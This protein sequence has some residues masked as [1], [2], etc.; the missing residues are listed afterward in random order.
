VKVP[1]ADTEDGLHETEY[2][3]DTLKAGGIR[4]FSESKNVLCGIPSRHPSQQCGNTP[5]TL[6]QAVMPRFNRFV[7]LDTTRVRAY[8]LGQ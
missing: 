8:R 7:W 2:V 6:P 4:L 3:L 1:L 5:A